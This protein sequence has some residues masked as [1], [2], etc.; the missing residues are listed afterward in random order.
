MCHLAKELYAQR[1]VLVDVGAPMQDIQ[2][3]KY[4]QRIDDRINDHATHCP[5][6]TA[7]MGHV[8]EAAL[9]RMAANDLR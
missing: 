6:C 5:D 8:R 9:Q 3:L 1:D 2:V 7:Y 4:V